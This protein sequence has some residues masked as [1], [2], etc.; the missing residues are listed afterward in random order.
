MEEIRRWYDRD[1]LLSKMMKILK[2]S[3][4]DFQIKMAINLIKVIIEHHIDTDQFQTMSDIMAA[5]N[6][7]H[8]DKGNARWYD[9][10]N[11]LKTAITMLESCSDE[12]QRSITKE[13]ADKIISE[14]NDIDAKNQEN[15]DELEPSDDDL[16]EIEEEEV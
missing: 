6:D 9:A 16:E 15:D 11:T 12:M 14:F 3:D 13:I 8:I 1:P 2:N 4:D 10:D 5:V 7:G